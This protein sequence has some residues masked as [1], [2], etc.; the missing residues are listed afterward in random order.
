VHVT[1]QGNCKVLHGKPLQTKPPHQ[2]PP[3]QHHHPQHSLQCPS[4]LVPPDPLRVL[5]QVVQPRVLQPTQRLQQ[6]GHQGG[7]ER[8]EG[9]G[10]GA[11]HRL[12]QHVQRQRPHLRGWLG[13]LVGHQVGLWVL[14]S[15]KLLSCLPQEVP[16]T[17]PERSL[18]TPTLNPQPLTSATVLGSPV[19]RNRG[20]STA[21]Q[22]ATSFE[23]VCDV[24]ISL[25]EVPRSVLLR[26]DGCTHRRVG[27][28]RGWESDLLE[29]QCKGGLCD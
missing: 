21:Q 27:S 1:K 14:S 18:P 24:S 9:G 19:S 4:G 6:A 11:A 16:A 5:L 10:A 26:M 8:D 29:H 22:P 3:P 23:G 25:R 12:G 7:G 13:W 28:W 15:A 17:Q 2:S 20:S